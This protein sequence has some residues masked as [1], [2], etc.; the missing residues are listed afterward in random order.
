MRLRL[1]ISLIFFSFFSLTTLYGI[2]IGKDNFSFFKKQLIWF[3][4]GLS[5][6]IILKN[7]FP[8]TWIKTNQN[9]SILIYLISILLLIGVLIFGKRVHHC[10]GWLSFFGL[11]FQPVEFAKLGLI[12]CLGKYFSLRHI[13]IYRITNLIF[14]AFYFLIPFGLVLLQ[15]DLGSAMILFFIWFGLT[16]ASGIK[17]KH[18]L[19]ICLIIVVLFIFSW[20]HFLKEYQKQRIITFLH[21]EEE[22]LGYGYQSIQAKI[23]IGEGGWFG[24]GLGKGNQIMFGFLPQ[25]HSDFIFASIANSFGLIG[26]GL[27]LGAYFLFFSYLINLAKRIS[28]NLEKFFILG[29]LLMVFSHFIIHIGANLGVL[30]ITGISLPFLSYGGSNLIINFIFLGIIESFNLKFYL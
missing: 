10:K 4:I 16:I 19:T 9:F 7:T 27:V 14:S 3:L 26:V 24:K 30:P 20:H 12:L 22:P 15:P 13:E 29:Y 6:F 23:A 28:G 2:G 17:T 1:V 11:D 18:F 5:I 21:P 8:W 25:P